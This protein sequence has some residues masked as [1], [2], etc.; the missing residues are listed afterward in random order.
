MIALAIDLGAS[1]GKAVAGRLDGARLHVE[2]VHR[3]ANDPVRVAGRLHWDILRLLHELKQGVRAA[4]HAGQ[5]M[6]TSIGIDAWGLDFGLLD[7]QGELVGNPYH[8]RDEQW[9]GAMADVLAIVPRAEIFARTGI[10]FMPINTLYQL[11]AMQQ[12]NASAL[13][14]ASSLLMI[15]D[16]LRYFLSGE[17]S[18]ECT[19]ASTTQFLGLV[20]GDWDRPLLE[21]LGLPTR[22]LTPVVPP[23]SLAGQLR[24]DVAEDVGTGPIPVVAVAGHDTASA[25]AAI[26]AAEPFAYLSCGTWSLLGTELAQPVV[27]DQALAWN[28]T[29]E[30]GVGGTYRLL[31][32]IMGLW[33]VE[34]CRRAWEDSGCWPG[35]DAIAAA[36]V[37]A[38]AFLTWVDPDDPRFLNPR[39]MPKAVVSYCQDTGQPVPDTPGAIMRCILESLALT[40]RLVLERTE[41]LAGRC[42]PGLHIVGGGTRNETLLQF[43]ADAI[44]RPV[45][46][47]PAEATAIGN[48]LCQLLAQGRIATV[49][50][51]RELV[52]TSF[53]IAAFEP[54]DTDAWNAAFERFLALRTS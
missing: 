13:D 35:Y 23:A 52:R 27:T 4:G 1:S 54:C 51:G 32:N 24:L 16:L 48:V 14:R 46:S 47:G 9:Q 42:F 11:F 33:L 38:P 29:N 20:T 19:E 45:W 26:P 41:H 8:Y 2:E 49:A 5:G 30:R 12:R 43:T 53:S 10:Q 34:G 25:V 36:A 7:H 21:R 50:E 6:V 44:G 18:S 22:L 31:K 15:P 39:D 3:F 37:A 40:Y 17:Q 28:F